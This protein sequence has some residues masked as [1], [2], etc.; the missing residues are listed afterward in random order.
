MKLA[1]RHKI[2]LTASVACLAVGFL[3][4][5]LF[6]PQVLFL[7]VLHI[8]P[9]HHLTINNSLLRH[10]VTGYVSDT[11]WVAALCFVTVA[12]TEMKHLSLPERIIILAL[13]VLLELAQYARLVA[14]T[15]D[16][17]DIAVYL[18][19]ILVFI[20]LFPGLLKLQR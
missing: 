9:A 14:G 15:F 17:I 6:S 10:I 7:A 16:P 8:Q 20:F 5:L 2:F 3:N 4:Y 18:S 12:F 13:P 1:M 11:M 19:I